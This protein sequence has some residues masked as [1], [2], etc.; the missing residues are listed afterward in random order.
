M[1]PNLL[2][3]LILPLLLQILNQVIPY[4]GYLICEHEVDVSWNYCFI[5]MFGQVD[6]SLGCY[7]THET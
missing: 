1:V 3:S 4:K 2:K 7:L 5:N 6:I